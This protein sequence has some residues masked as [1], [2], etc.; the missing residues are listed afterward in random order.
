MTEPD[1]GIDPDLIT[2]DLSH[3][4]A[5]LVPWMSALRALPYPLSSHLLATAAIAEGFVRNGRFRR[6][7]SWAG[8]RGFGGAA[9][10]RLAVTLLANHGR[11]V[12]EEAV[13]GARSLGDL[14]E[15]VSVRGAERLA[16]LQESGA[17]LLGFH[18]GPPKTWLVLRALGYPVRFAG[19]LE[20]A[21]RDR[22]WEAALT[23]G[24]AIRLPDG[25]PKTRTAALFRI[26][27]ALKSGA[28]VYI[29]ADGPFGA[30]AFRIDLAGG[31]VV[32]R[33]GWLAAR[34]AAGVQTFPVLTR[35][36]HGGRV[37]EVHPALP[38]ADPDPSR[39]A[40]QCQA[41]LTPLIAD[42]VR[43]FPDQCRWVAMPRWPG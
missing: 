32:I 37:I 29:T 36:E 25:D 2:T 5:R 42:Y 30:E 8:D 22:R 23:A 40:L 3:G 13:L 35:H 1:A 31:P 39:D 18:L 16:N 9:Q 4:P 14:A 34:R 26:R 33:S 21:A 43:R 10:W 38:S 19:R 6:A 28:L 20:A 7:L 27:N 41:A 17:L 12:A 15:N 24:E 11:F